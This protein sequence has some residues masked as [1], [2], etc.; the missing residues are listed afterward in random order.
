MSLKGMKGLYLCCQKYQRPFVEG[1]IRERGEGRWI[2]H[3]RLEDADLV[4]VIGS[5]KTPEME[6][7]ILQ[8]GRLGIS[9]EYV[10][11]KFFSQEI[12]EALLSNRKEVQVS[13]TERA[14][15]HDRER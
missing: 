9:L 5:A 10:N 13:R 11:E 12:Y 3:D 2:L 4:L 8:A 7:E 14:K 1:R 15:S 6:Q